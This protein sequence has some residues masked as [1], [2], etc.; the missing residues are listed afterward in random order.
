MKQPTH[1]AIHICNSHRL[2]HRPKIAKEYGLP[3]LVGTLT[4]F[5]I[6]NEMIKHES[7]TLYISNGGQGAKYEDCNNK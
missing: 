5:D 1:K 3:T 6:M 4:K 2:T 7:T